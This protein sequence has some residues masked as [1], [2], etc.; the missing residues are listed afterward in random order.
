MTVKVFF[1]WVNK[2]DWTSVSILK[3]RDNIDLKCRI[4]LSS[5]WFSNLCI[6][7]FFVVDTCDVE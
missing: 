5:D 4:G 1:D 2:N 6:D 3:F 7:A